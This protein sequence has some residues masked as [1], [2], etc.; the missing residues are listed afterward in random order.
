[1][2]YIV[3][4]VSPVAMG[5]DALSRAIVDC[6]DLPAARSKAMQLL[7]I[8]T[9]QGATHAQVLSPDGEV[10]IE[11]HLDHADAT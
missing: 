7:E 8:W 6:N 10:S 3:E 2:K 1:M 4:I 11:V 5:H 9:K